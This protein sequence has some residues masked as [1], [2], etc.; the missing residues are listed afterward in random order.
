MVV[1]L[2]L[3]PP[4]LFFSVFYCCSW[5]TKRFIY[6]IPHT[7]YLMTHNG[8]ASSDAG[9]KA[10]EF[11]PVWDI[12]REKILAMGYGK[13]FHVPEDRS[14]INVY[15]LNKSS[16]VFEDH[17]F[18]HYSRVERIGISGNVVHIKLKDKVNV[19]LYLD[20][21]RISFSAHFKKEA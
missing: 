18:L 15:S 9:K 4:P 5:Y 19:M 17:L 7:F 12:T 13:T 6:G 14:G 8:V 16:G 10:D 21:G 2:S 1:F 3:L 11:K 20:S